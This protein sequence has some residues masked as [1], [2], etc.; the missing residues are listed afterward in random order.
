MVVLKLDLSDCV[1]VARDGDFVFSA[2]LVDR[3]EAHQEEELLFG[4]E[5]ALIDGGLGGLWGH[6]ATSC[7]RVLLSDG[8]NGRVFDV[9]PHLPGLLQRAHRHLVI[10]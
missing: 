10:R 6:T 3:A 1:H 8:R 7:E 5:F 9:A 4:T 2:R